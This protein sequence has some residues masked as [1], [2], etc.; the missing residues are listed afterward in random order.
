[1]FLGARHPFLLVVACLAATDV[2]NMSGQLLSEFVPVTPCRVLDTRN[3]AG[4]LGGPIMI[5]ASTRT[6]PIASNSCG[7]PAT[8]SGYSMNITVIPRGSLRY[9]TLWPTGQPMPTT[10]TMVSLYGQILSNAALVASGTSGSVNLFVTDTTDV[11]IDLNGYF[12]SPTDSTRQSTAV[13]AGASSASSQ[14]TGVGFNALHVNDTGNGNTAIGSGAVSSNTSGNNNVGMGSGALTF[15]AT[16]SA[17]TA[18]GAQ[19]SL[20]NL[21]GNDNVALGFSALWS[22]NAGSNNTAVGAIASFSNM[23]GAGNTAIGYGTLYNNTDGSSNIA[24]GYQAGYQIAAGSY[25]IDIGSQ[26]TASDSNAIRI[27]SPANQTSAYLAGV[28][29]VN[30]S[31]GSQVLINSNGQLGTVQSS[32]RYKRD[33]RD[34]GDASDAIMRLRPVTFR[35]DHTAANENLSLQYGLIGEEVA[36]VYPELVVHGLDGQIDS[37]Q[38]YE[39]PALLLNEVQKQHWALKKQESD[40]EEARNAL[41]QQRNEISILQSQVKALQRSLETFREP[42]ASNRRQ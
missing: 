14:N 17:N 25:N 41:E 4:P 39:L 34:M 5:G 8:A 3:P 23:A 11:I 30:V 15:N 36:N 42:G 16:G 32:R 10:A 20:N 22:S 12:L 40:L 27:G 1:M 18:V 28:Y 6:F 29:G 21:V 9:I 2:Q 37:V 31:S 13:G 24:V 33:I 38:Y 35:Y 19:A 7:I 26:G